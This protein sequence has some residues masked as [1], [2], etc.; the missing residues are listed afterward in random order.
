MA[1]V[2][3]LLIITTSAAHACSCEPLSQGKAF[4]KA[5]AVFM[6]QVIE[7]NQLTRREDRTGE[8]FYPY[9][10]KF[11]VEEYWKG[12]KTSE[13]IVLSDQGLLPCHIGKFVVGESYL[14]YAYGKKLLAP[15]N[16]DRSRSVGAASED[17][18][19]L[20]NGKESFTSAAPPDNSFNR[21]RN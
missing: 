17:L 7:I 14:V 11:K 20:G 12:V 3:G 8:L 18:Q 2:L 5:K 13:I 15:I 6:G 9:A 1:F 16:C 4:R 21:T 19:K 10:V